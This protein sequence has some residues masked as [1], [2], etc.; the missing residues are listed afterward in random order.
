MT[1]RIAA[2]G[3]AV[4]A[5]AAVV[6][7][8][9]VL[10]Q[11]P[12]HYA[13]GRLQLADLLTWGA[14]S[15]PLA[16]LVTDVTNRLLGPRVARRVVYCGFALALPLTVLVPTVMSRVGMLSFLPEFE[17]LVRIAVA[18]GAAFLV[19]QLLDIGIFNRLRSRSWWQA[20]AFSSLFGSFADTVVFFGLAFAPAFVIIGANDA[21]ALEGA[22]LLGLYQA[23]A[24]R[25][26]SWAL[27]DFC[28][29]LL[30]DVAALVPYRLI[31]GYFA[32]MRPAAVG[33]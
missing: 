6:V 25:W 26:M 17:R 31:V 1:G 14:F 7:L 33:G 9:N 10:V 24:P 30:I 5:M 28:V 22:P 2:V 11:Y 21:F 29:K 27:G 19:G 23:D 12:V 20:P 13:F 32:P 3:A 8:S 16:F 15:Y 18:S 4:A